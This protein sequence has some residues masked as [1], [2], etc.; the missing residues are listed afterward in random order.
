MKKT[1]D[2][3][4]SNSNL[5][6]LL[7]WLRLV[8]RAVVLLTFQGGSS[9]RAAGVLVL[10]HLNLRPYCTVTDVPSIEY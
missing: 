5:F 4:I 3:K 7:R 6:L 8:S 1:S 9:L 10:A 2:V